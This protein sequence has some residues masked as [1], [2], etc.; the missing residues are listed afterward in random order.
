MKNFILNSACLLIIYL[1]TID[2]VMSQNIED[3]ESFNK[4][5]LKQRLFI[6][7]NFGLSFGNNQTFIEASPLIGYRLTP[8]LSA[9]LGPIYRYYE[10]QLANS[11]FTESQYG[12]RV[13]SRYT[14]IPN[15]FAHAEYE[16]LNLTAYDRPEEPRIYIHSVLVGGGYVQPLGRSAVFIMLLYNLN[17]TFYTPYQNPIIR[18]GVNIGF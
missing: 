5:S 14:I 15:L 16:S 10:I 12:M 7:G 18:A 8:R 1:V 2:Q 6:N 9:G 4:L 13:F 3:R 17:Q 11:R